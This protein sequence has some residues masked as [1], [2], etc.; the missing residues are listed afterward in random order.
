MNRAHKKKTTSKKTPDG[1]SSATQGPAVTRDG[2]QQRYIRQHLLVGWGALLLFIILGAVLES[3]HGFKVSWYDNVGMETR[4]LT[5]R[6]AHAHGTFLAVINLTFA[7]TLYL[8]GESAQGAWR[9]IASACLLG[10]T[11]ALPGGFFLG[12]VTIY[13]GDPGL[14]IF[15][16]PVGVL[17]LFIAVS[18]TTYRLLRR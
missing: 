4:R 10:A 15:L 2:E 1:L 8:M 3:L 9:R 14:G 13:G 5:W 11:I 18:L 17:L 7:L 6:L 12:G 16:S